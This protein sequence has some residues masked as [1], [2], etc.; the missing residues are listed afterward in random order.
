MTPSE[1]ANVA[2][3]QLL[4][5]AAQKVSS[6]LDSFSGWLLA[7]FGAALAF[8]IANLDTVSGYID[9]NSIKCAAVLFLISA[10]LAVF[11]KLLASFIAAG[12]AAGIAGAA[13]GKDLAERGIELDVTT[14]FAE[15]K[16]ALYWPGSL[17]ASRAF[18]KARAGDFAGPGR[19][20]VKLSQL[21]ALV[22]IIQAA[23]S[24]AAAAVI[25]S[26]LAV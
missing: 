23:L 11:E 1:H 4:I 25:V 9:F 22:V 20:Y 21:Q 2:A 3:G 14:F 7:G 13:F 19:M 10:V 18:T 6:F 15:T 17:F 24:L 26:G 16:R 8:F 5:T 12:T